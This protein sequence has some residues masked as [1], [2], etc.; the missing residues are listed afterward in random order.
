M[1]SVPIIDM[2]DGTENAFLSNFYP[3]EI[4]Y[5]DLKFATT[6][7]AYQWEKA[8]EGSVDKDGQLWSEKIRL[9][10]TAAKTKKYGRQCTLR[11]DWEQIKFRVMKSVLIEKFRDTPLWDKLD[12]TGDAYLIEGNTWH[13]NC[14]GICLKKDCER[15]CWKKQGLNYLGLFLMEL[16]STIRRQKQEDKIMKEFLQKEG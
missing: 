10:P 13:D 2:F 7:H 16:R 15:G 14:F 1:N 4:I 12:A 11:P 6:E 5:N 8:I 3:Y 9:A